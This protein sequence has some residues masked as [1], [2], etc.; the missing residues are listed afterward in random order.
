M[1]EN[2]NKHIDSLFKTEAKNFQYKPS[3]DTW[4]TIK[5]RLQKNKKPRVI[6]LK[7]ALRIAAAVLILGMGSFYFYDSLQLPSTSDS[8]VNLSMNKEVDKDIP[9]PAIQQAQSIQKTIPQE[10]SSS[11]DEKKSKTTISTLNIE[12]DALSSYGYKRSQLLYQIYK[13]AERNQI[14]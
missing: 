14:F 6:S 1:M 7:W 4:K 10:S 2:K 11:V 5:E 12:D 9:I 13:N 8:Y 3:E